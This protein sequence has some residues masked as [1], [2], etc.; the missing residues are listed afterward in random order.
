VGLHAKYLG[1]PMENGLD[2][3]LRWANSVMQCPWNLDCSQGSLH[4][5]I[6]SVPYIIYTFTQFTL[7]H[8]NN[9]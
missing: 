2:Q 7:A 9:G 1:M 3:P 6:M 5:T 4:F 8:L